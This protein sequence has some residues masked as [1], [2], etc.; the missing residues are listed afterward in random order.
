MISG[1]EAKKTDGDRST[2][3]HLHQ[4]LK[5]EI[6]DGTLRPGDS[7]TES[8]LAH[9]FKVSRTPV[10][11]ALSALEKERLVQRLPFRG[12]IVSSITMDDVVDLLQLRM[13]LEPEAARMVASRRG[14]V[15]SEALQS[16]HDAGMAGEL[17]PVEA[18]R[19]FHQMIA[20][21]AGN[22]MMAEILAMLHD[23]SMRLVYGYMTSLNCEQILSSHAKTIEA[24]RRGD[25][26]GAAA[27]IVQQLRDFQ[28]R[29]LRR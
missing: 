14:P 17:D 16:I 9:R 13:I 22:R 15:V 12:Y 19:R 24:L 28:D 4:S 5:A 29:L 8:E 2:W 23:R 25:P 18:D 11:E 10:R 20:D 3:R 7:F 26:D 6:L 27:S 1:A 21:E